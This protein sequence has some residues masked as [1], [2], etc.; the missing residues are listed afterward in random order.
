MLRTKST[1]TCDKHTTTHYM[2]TMYNIILL[3]RLTS[4]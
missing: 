1:S 2:S 4:C 3:S